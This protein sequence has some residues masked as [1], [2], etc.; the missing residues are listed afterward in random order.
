MKPAA[1]N[2]GQNDDLG[3]ICKEMIEKTLRDGNIKDAQAIVKHVYKHRLG[4]GTQGK[5]P[6]F[7]PE[8]QDRVAAMGRKP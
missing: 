5:A 3:K 1:M 4:K 2:P 7:K 6:S 8:V